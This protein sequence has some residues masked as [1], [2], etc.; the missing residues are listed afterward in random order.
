MTEV[1]DKA[2][3]GFT[4]TSAMNLKAREHQ[5]LVEGMFLEIG[6]SMITAK[7]K[8]GK[9]T[10]ARQLAYSVAEGAD[11][12]NAPVKQGEVIYFSL[13]GPEEI[14]K[15]H[16]VQLGYT[17]KRGIVHVIHELMPFHGEDGL[18]RLDVTLSGLQNVRLVVLDPAHKFLRPVDSDK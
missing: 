1:T 3:R 8:V 4:L 9:S 11:F 18:Q 17:E 7:P 6:L 2:V 12:L 5:W 10:F 14:V 16:L 15:E 13:E